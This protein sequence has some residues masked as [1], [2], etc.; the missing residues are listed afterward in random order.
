ME[1]YIKKYFKQGHNFQDIL[2]FL[3]KFHKTDISLITLKR[4]LKKLDL[5]R[6]NVQESPMPDIIYA[7]VTEIFRSGYNLG[8]R[9]LWKL[10][11]A[12]YGFIVKRDTVYAILKISDP[13]GLAA[14][15]G[16]RLR[17]RIDSTP[18]PNSLLHVDGWDKLGKL[19]GIYV[20]GCIDGFSRYIIWLGASNSN[21][22]PRVAAYYFLKSIKH[23]NAMPS[24][25]RSDKG[26]ENVNIESLQTTLR[27][28][29]SDQFA[30]AKSY[31]KG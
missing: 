7:V 11:K 16:N 30:G 24:R 13:E 22:D 23:I 15:Y 18:G 31:H 28:L 10:L 19:F 25:V 21:K 14:R 8:Y 1:T 12:K 3:S 17:R 29:H 27:S 26:T 4:I 6:K 9:A 2:R 20:H 5:R